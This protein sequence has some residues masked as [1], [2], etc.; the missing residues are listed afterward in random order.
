MEMFVFLIVVT[1][2]NS[3]HTV[4]FNYV[5]CT[6]PSSASMKLIKK[7]AKNKRNKNYFKKEKAQ[8]KEFRG[9]ENLH[10]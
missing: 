10:N 1:I 6:V 9:S 7:K 3:D 8:K 2:I 4:H 5:P